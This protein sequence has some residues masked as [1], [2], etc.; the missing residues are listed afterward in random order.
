MHKTVYKP[1]SQQM[2]TFPSLIQC[3]WQLQP[4]GEPTDTLGPPTEP[5]V[6]LSEPVSVCAD[7]LVSLPHLRHFISSESK[8]NQARSGFSSAAL[9]LPPHLT[10]SNHVKTVELAWKWKLHS[11]CL[12]LWV[13]YVVNKHWWPLIC[14]HHCGSF[15]LWLW[16]RC[17]F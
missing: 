14:W 2:I 16:R 10:S 9:H 17:W 15:Q 11:L 7:L 1:P 3:D 13:L 8:I 5:N 4:A 12:L 6:F